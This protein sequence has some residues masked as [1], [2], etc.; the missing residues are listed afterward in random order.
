M[1]RNGAVD[2]LCAWVKANTTLFHPDEKLTAAEIGDGNVNLVYRVSNLRGDRS[3][4]VK[5]ALPYLKI[6]GESWPLTLDRNR[7]EYEAMA[8]QAK[9]NGSY[10]PAL[11]H[12]DGERALFIMEDCGSM[13]VV[14]HGLMQGRTYPRL[15]GQLGSYLANALYFTSDFGMEAKAK[16]ARV[17]EFI[18][19][20]LCDLT[21]RLVFTDPYYDAASNDIHAPIR[22]S[23]ESLW[24]DAGLLAE[25]DW[26]RFR[27]MNKP[28][29]LLHGDLHTGSIFATADGCKVFDSEFAF[30]GPIG[31]DLGVLVANLIIHS[32]Y[33]EQKDPAEARN[34]EKVA[35][36]PRNYPMEFLR[37][38]WSSFEQRIGE[39]LACGVRTRMLEP[40]LF[41]AQ[42][43]REVVQE[44]AGFAG[45]EILRRVIGLA[46]VPEFEAA[47]NGEER[48][49]I[50][51]LALSVG[52]R[53][54]RECRTLEG[55]EGLL[56][57]VQE[58]SAAVQ[59]AAS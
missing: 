23:A 33:W 9:H 47:A 46:H 36:R 16:K 10:I 58:A 21:E 17:A 26:L 51:L 53:L 56:K 30:Y 3:V 22:P 45:C 43:L 59:L 27:F 31:F 37:E 35:D 48:A 40:G 15:P 52:R 1:K 12:R 11:Y 41:I 25:I 29:A 28:E 14:R 7:L 39:L 34:E 5:Q 50:E 57:I 24:K 13:E 42:Y 6:S 38:L 49:R 20:E 2:E 32:C 18:N 19:P 44:T 4:I 55:F 8:L 54:I